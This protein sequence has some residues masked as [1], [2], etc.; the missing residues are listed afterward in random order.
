MISTV[1]AAWNIVKW[2]RSQKKQLEANAEEYLTD[3]R[4]L[5][6]RR[7]AERIFTA[8]AEGD[9]EFADLPKPVKWFFASTKADNHL[10][11]FGQRFLKSN[12]LQAYRTHF[13]KGE[14]K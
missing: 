8:L 5:A 11:K 2:L 12:K 14:T 9:G 7:E 10:G 1:I 3:D 4:A 13:I 6:W